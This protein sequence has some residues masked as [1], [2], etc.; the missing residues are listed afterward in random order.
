LNFPDF[1]TGNRNFSGKCGYFSGHVF[2]APK[3]RTQ[4][5]RFAAR[6]RGKD[7]KVFA[8]SPEGGRGQSTRPEVAERSGAGEGRFSAKILKFGRNLYKESMF[9]GENEG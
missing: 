5:E 3:A 4:L 1:F 6:E 8:L 9:F 2:I 7:L